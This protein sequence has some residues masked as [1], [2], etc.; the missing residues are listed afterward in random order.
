MTILLHRVL[1]LFIVIIVIQFATYRIGYGE[2][3]RILFCGFFA[4]LHMEMVGPFLI[5]TDK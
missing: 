1:G 5:W 3:E 4:W 2:V